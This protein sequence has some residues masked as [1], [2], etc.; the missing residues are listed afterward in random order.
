[1]KTSATPLPASVCSKR[2]MATPSTSRLGF[3]RKILSVLF[4]SILAIFLQAQTTNKGKQRFYKVAFSNSHAAKPFRSFSSLFY[5]D[6]HPGIDIGYESVFSRKN[7]T[8]WFYEIRMG[9][10]FHQWVQHNIPLYGNVG[11]RYE[12]FPS[13]LAE[14]KLGGGY[15]LSI[16]QSKVFEITESDGVKEKKNFGRSQVIGNF[17]AA[18][19]KKLSAASGVHLFLEYKQQIQ[20]PFIREY[21]PLLPYNSMLIGIKIPFKQS[22]PK[23][24]P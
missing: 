22:S 14:I 15:Q 8:Q 11:L 18:V 5:T 19:T 6:F 20:T 17:G 24:K 4:L 21:M 7:R 9:Y 2:R 3:T 13:W 1:M 16:P 23:P 12:A 10:M